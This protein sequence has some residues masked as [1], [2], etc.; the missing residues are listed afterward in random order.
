MTS[1]LFASAA[2]YY[3][4]YRPDYPPSLYEVARQQFGLDG[5]PRG[6]LLDL[7]TGPGFVALGLA[8]HFERVVGVDPDEE[9]ITLAVAAGAAR[10]VRHAEWRCLS[11]E[12]LADLDGTTAGPPYRLVSIGSALHWMDQ[13]LVLNLIRGR[14]EASGGLLL[15]GM[16]GFITFD[17]LEHADPISRIVVPMIRQYLGEER[18][19]GTGTFA[20]TPRRWQDYLEES[21]YVG[22]ESGYL[23]LEVTF[24]HDAV[25]GLTYSTSFANRHL[26]GERADD[27]DHDLRAALAR[28][29]PS[30]EVQRHFDVEWVIGR[31]PA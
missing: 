9:M 6:T 12:S 24:D 27:F 25:V 18:R 19:A 23:P 22:I 1:D 3:A 31:P 26:L 21:G 28:E 11:A 13:P 10:D 17:D 7:G 20:G 16:P 5:P 14:L 8:R 30:G 4:A 2:S 15:V 29:A